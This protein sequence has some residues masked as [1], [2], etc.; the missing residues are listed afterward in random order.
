[1]GFVERLRRFALITSTS[2]FHA[3]SPSSAAPSI[4]FLTIG[5]QLTFHASF[6]RS[7]ARTQ[8]RFT[9]FAVINL[10]RDL[11]PQECAHAG[12]TSG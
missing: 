11:H 9:S 6:P 5:S 7:V 10:R 8:L 1:M 4:R 3:R 2:R 12:R